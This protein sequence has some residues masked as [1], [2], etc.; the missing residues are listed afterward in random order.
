MFTQEGYPY[1]NI[2]EYIIMPTR[3]ILLQLLPEMKS[4]LQLV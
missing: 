4:K 3:L 2:D 1:E